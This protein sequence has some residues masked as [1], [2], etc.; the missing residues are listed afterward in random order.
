MKKAF[1]LVELSIV[2]II[3]GLLVA[4]VTGGSKLIQNANVQ[5]LMRDMNQISTAYKTFRLSYDAFPGDFDAATDFWS[6]TINGDGDGKIEHLVTLAASANGTETSNAFEHMSKAEIFPG[7]F[8]NDVSTTVADN[9]Y[10]YASKLNSNAIILYYKDSGDVTHTG[11]IASMQTS[12]LLLLG[13]N[14]NSVG[15]F[16]SG[17][18]AFT[19]DKKLDDGLA[20]SGIVAYRDETGVT[21]GTTTPAS[22]VNGTAYGLTDDSKG[23]NLVYQLD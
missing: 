23:C 8:I 14:K 15:A 9:N 4:G 2:L 1:S 12:N 18:N 3:V 11:F 7:S 10:A 16:I 13:S 6:G 19:I 20:T 22:C 17:R 5:S 21:N